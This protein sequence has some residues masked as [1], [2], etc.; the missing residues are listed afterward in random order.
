MSDK[1][2]SRTTRT[3][4]Q[5][6]GTSGGDRINA[7]YKD[8]ENEGITEN[9]DKIYGG[10]GNDVVFASGGDDLI[11]GGVGNDHLQGNGGNDAL[12]GGLGNDVVK[13]GDGTV[14]LVGW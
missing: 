8:T 14:T 6:D 5:I 9:G 12:D 13:G 11:Y 3:A 1:I 7:E 10:G 2:N 4:N